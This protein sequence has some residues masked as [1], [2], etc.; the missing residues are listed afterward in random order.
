MRERYL[1]VCWIGLSIGLLCESAS[2]IAGGSGGGAER[3]RGGRVRRQSGEDVRDCTANPPYLPD[4]VTDT[5]QRVSD[6]RAQMASNGIAAYIIPSEDAHGSEYVAS[7]DTRRAFISGLLGS[8]GLA[9]VTASE[10]KLWTDGRYFLQAEKEMDCQWDLMKIGATFDDPSPEEWLAQTLSDGDQI[11]FDPAL[12]SVSDYEYYT[13][14]LKKQQ[15]AKTITMKSIPNNLI[16]AIWSDQPPYNPD[17]VITI[18][19]AAK[20]TGET[21]QQKVIDGAPGQNST[22][23]Q[24]QM[25]KG[26]TIDALVITKLDEIAWLFNLR[27][28]DVPYNPMFVSYAIVTKT[29]TR[30]Y[31]YNSTSTDR[32]PAAVKTH[33]NVNANGLSC[34]SDPCV[35][36]KDYNDFFADLQSLNRTLA[37]KI[38][39]SDRASY[40]VYESISAENRY[41]A[42]SPLLLMKAVKSDKEAQGMEDAHAMDSIALCNLGAWMQKT[43]DSLED[44]MTGDIKVISEQ[45]VMQKCVDERAKFASNRGLSFGTIAGMGPHGAIIHYTSTPET[46][47]P[48]TKAG[49][50][51]LD[52]GGQYLEGTCDITRTFH[53]G[54]PTPFMKEAYTRVLL[55]SIDLAMAVF[56]TG[57]YGRDIDSI[58]R[59]QL[60][61]GGLEYN[62][63]TGHGIGHFLNVHEDPINIGDY[64]GERSLRRNVFVSDE[65]GYYEDGSFGI[66]IENIVRTVPADVEHD[67]GGHQYMTFKMISLVP[68]EPNLIDFSM[69]NNKQLE[70]YNNYNKRVRDEIGP[71]SEL[72]EA[73]KAWMMSKTEPVEYTFKLGTGNSGQRTTP[74]LVAI[75]MTLLLGTLYS[76]W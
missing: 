46:D 74:S 76:V 25:V 70:Y 37:G 71:R 8:A 72:T 4:T 39:I 49:T 40:A 58:A 30:L 43:V 15:P 36:V 42:A 52:S 57:I 65:P 38:W 75:L 67:F 23:Q 26:E 45:I 9:V 54:T 73:G 59:N 10:A 17:T 21:W 62:H 48:V 19:D 51:L 66:R 41:V 32:V 3:E 33:L 50:F 13:A 14:E 18:L 2:P 35:L 29:D 61:S 44:P 11:G 64:S 68:L 27:G 24:L 6:L 1:L 56:R 20:Y 34:I 53:F 12:M 5:T 31:L 63:G 69:F 55:G 47:V 28:D 7:R 16:D 22:R 60:W